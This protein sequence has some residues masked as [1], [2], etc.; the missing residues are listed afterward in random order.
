MLKKNSSNKDIKPSIIVSITPRLLDTE[1]AAAYLCATV[2]CIE[3][4]F[5]S[6]EVRSFLLGKKRVVDV[7]VLDLYV[8]RRNAE[9]PVWVEGPR[10]QLQGVT[11]P[12]RAAR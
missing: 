3:E 9:K 12:A 10:G 5:R 7:R 1:Q 2:W 6:G 8:D 11:T 4:L